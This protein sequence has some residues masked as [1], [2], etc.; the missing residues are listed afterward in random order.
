MGKSSAW[1]DRELTDEELI[2]IWK[3]TVSG[4]KDGSIPTF[5][6]KSAL[7]ENVLRRLESTR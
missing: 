6:E 5:D 3:S 4:V 2:A 1:V 7:I